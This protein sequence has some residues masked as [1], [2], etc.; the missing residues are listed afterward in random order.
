GPGAGKGTQSCGWWWRSDPAAPGAQA[1]CSLALG[2]PSGSKDGQLIDE[3]IREGK[4]VPV[5]ISLGLLKKAM[6]EA[7]ENRFLID[8]FP[9]NWDNVAGWDRVM[10]AAVDVDGVIFYDCP[11]AVLEERLLKRGETSGRTDD[12]IESARKRFKTYIESTLPVV[13]H[14]EAAGLVARI[15]GHCGGPDAVF[16]RTRAAV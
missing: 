16:E 8:G 13:Q 4:I 2:G 7:P 9:R 1:T 3:Y 6:E 14:Y 10:G 5:E 12:N 11:E 15:P